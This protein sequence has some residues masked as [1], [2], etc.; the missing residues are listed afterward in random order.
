MSYYSAAAP[1]PQETSRRKIVEITVTVEQPCWPRKPQEGAYWQVAGIRPVMVEGVRI[2][3]IVGVAPCTLSR[4][5]RVKVRGSLG[6]RHGKYQI[7]FF[8]CELV[9]AEYRN[10]I[11]TILGRN[12]VPKARGLFL[13]SEL[14]EDFARKIAEDPS[15]IKRLLPRIREPAIETIVKSCNLAN[16]GGAL[17][18]ALNAVGAPQVTIDDASAFDLEKQSIYSLV[19][20]GL[21][22]ARADALAQ[23]PDIQVLQPFNPLDPARIAHAALVEIK[24]RCGLWGHIGLPLLDILG[25]LSLTYGLDAGKCR[26]AL[27]NGVGRRGLHIDDGPNERVFLDAHF[28]AEENIA[29]IVTSYLAIVRPRK[30]TTLSKSARIMIGTDNELVIKFS[31]VQLKCLAG[32]IDSLFAVLTGGPWLGEDNPVGRTR[33]SLRGSACCGPV[34]KG[35]SSRTRT[36]R[37]RMCDRGRYYRRATRT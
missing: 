20:R 22:F 23:H 29:R 18:Q 19:E 21:P 10:P 32:L 17:F 14:G 1:K 15:H 7:E 27:L 9:E 33:R 12:G 3:A 35:R 8:E 11:L 31:K 4:F 2:S 26:E 13:Q 5:V 24:S 25:W 34:G 6:V 36:D 16:A 37:R 30:R 28:K